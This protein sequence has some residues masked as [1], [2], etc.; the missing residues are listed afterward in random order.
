MVP[1]AGV[2]WN[3]QFRQMIPL[4]VAANPNWHAKQK[5]RLGRRC[6]CYK[7]STEI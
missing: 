6:D 7:Y 1:F 5:K 2:A 3:S 4:G